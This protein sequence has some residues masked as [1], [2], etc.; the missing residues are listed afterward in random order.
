MT[1]VYIG[2]GSNIDNPTAHISTAFI[3]IGQIPNSKLKR[4]S[5]LYR[6]SPMGNIDQPEFINAVVEL[7][8]ELSA[9]TLLGHMHTIEEKHG[10]VRTQHWGPR[11]LDLDLLLYGDHHIENRK[12]TVPHPGINDRNFVLCPLLEIVPEIVIPGSGS[13]K[14]I[15]ENIGINGL[16]KLNRE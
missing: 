4:Q 15:L 1:V 2:L 3:E 12:L 6:S 14:K 7:D 13:A 10:R 8:T 5:S 16:E 11:S 9:I